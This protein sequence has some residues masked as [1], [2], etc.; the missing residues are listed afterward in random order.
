MNL[1]RASDFDIRDSIQFFK[2]CL[3]IHSKSQFQKLL[4]AFSLHRYFCCAGFG[5]AIP[6]VGYHWK[7]WK[8]TLLSTLPIITLFQNTS[9]WQ[10]YFNLASVA[11]RT[12]VEN[13]HELDEDLNYSF[14]YDNSRFIGI[15]ILGNST[16]ITISHKGMVIFLLVFRLSF[17]FNLN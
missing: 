9:G 6:F 15:D 17:F 16:K 12:G 11:S 14:D 4:T 13:Y 2:S 1:F 7:I 10:G 3:I 8:S 5:S